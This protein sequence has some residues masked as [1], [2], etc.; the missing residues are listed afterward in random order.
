MENYA[1][2]ETINEQSSDALWL[3]FSFDFYDYH[4]DQL[5]FALVYSCYKV[6][7]DFMAMARPNV[8]N[9]QFLSR[10]TLNGEWSLSWSQNFLNLLKAGVYRKNE[11]E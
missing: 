3:L 6:N 11:S 7:V 9:S 2:W 10:S 1:G 4:V 8:S 5:D